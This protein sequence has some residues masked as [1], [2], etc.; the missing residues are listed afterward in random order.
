MTKIDKLLQKAE[1]FEKLAQEEFEA[2]KKER[3]SPKTSIFR[4]LDI[5]KSLTDRVG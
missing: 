2:V 1:Y 5:L 3:S 4:R